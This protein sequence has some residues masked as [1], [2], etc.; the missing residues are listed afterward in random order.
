MY[1][2]WINVALWLAWVIG[3]YAGGIFAARTRRAESWPALLSHAVPL[4]LGFFLIFHNWHAPLLAGRLYD[5]RWAQV[6]SDVVTAA[7]LL[8]TVWARLHLG[9][10]W[11]AVITLKQGHQLIRTGPYRIVR[12]PIYT[13]FIA[14]ALGSAT[15]MGTGDAIVGWV[16]V[17]TSCA[18][19][20]SREERLLTAEFGDAYLQFKRE[21]PML[22]PFVI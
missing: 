13:G 15:V 21:V 12:H 2:Y 4:G 8:F 18:I 9:K 22:V 20:I 6:A 11:S 17:V 14:A 10:Y 3:W 5:N 19:K 16:L 1:W 7:G